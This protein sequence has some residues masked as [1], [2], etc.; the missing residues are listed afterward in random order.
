MST[1]KPCDLLKNAFDDIH[2]YSQGLKHKIP[3][4]SIVGELQGHLNE[5][6]RADSTLLHEALAV[7]VMDVDAK[8]DITK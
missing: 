2:F 7:V 6:V 5:S 4:H 1:F 3:T 8:V